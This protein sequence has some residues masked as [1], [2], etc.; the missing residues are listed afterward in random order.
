[1]EDGRSRSAYLL[2]EAGAPL[3]HLALPELE[4]LAIPSYA[5][6]AGILLKASALPDSL[7]VRALLAS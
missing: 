3:G 6:M 7:C 5:S 1:M 2:S 4:I